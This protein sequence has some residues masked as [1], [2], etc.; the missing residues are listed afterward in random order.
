V[1]HFESKVNRATGTITGAEAL[2]RWMHPQCGM[3]MPDRV[4]PIAEKCGLIVPIGCWCCAK[5]VH[6]PSAGRGRIEA[7]SLVAFPQVEVVYMEPVIH[8]I[9]P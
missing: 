6:K 9:Q 7:A 5:H 8:A 4:V 2:L 3:V 1:L